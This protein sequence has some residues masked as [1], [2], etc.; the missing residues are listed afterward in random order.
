MCSNPNCTC[1]NCSGCSGLGCLGE[2]DGGA[3]FQNYFL[4]VMSPTDK[5]A[6][7]GAMLT[8]NF[9]PLYAQMKLAFADVCKAGV[10]DTANQFYEDNKTLIWCVGIASVI[11]AWY[12]YSSLTVVKRK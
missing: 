4:N 1:G 6:M 10:F 9:D 8:G 5:A 2:V 12:L 11:L 3:V 7:V